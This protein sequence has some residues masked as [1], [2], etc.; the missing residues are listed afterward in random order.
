MLS[1]NFDGVQYSGEV[2]YHGAGNKILQLT[3]WNYA[4]NQKLV[5][6][7]GTKI[8]IGNQYLLATKTLTAT[9]SADGNGAEWTFT[10]S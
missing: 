5:I 7:A 10:V 4:A 2:H 8:F 6:E 3:Q 1:K 9:C